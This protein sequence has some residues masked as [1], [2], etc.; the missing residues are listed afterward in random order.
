M[1]NGVKGLG[2]VQVVPRAVFIIFDVPSTNSLIASIVKCPG[3][4]P[5]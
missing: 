4:I 5:Y 3:R 2:Q 1:I